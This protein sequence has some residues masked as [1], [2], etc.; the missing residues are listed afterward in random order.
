MFVLLVKFLDYVP[1]RGDFAQVASIMDMHSI[2]L[3]TFLAVRP[4]IL[5]LCSKMSFSSLNFYLCIA[6]RKNIQI[7]CL[8]FGTC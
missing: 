3:G 1:I 6:R 5:L 7:C 2:V 4:P 8:R